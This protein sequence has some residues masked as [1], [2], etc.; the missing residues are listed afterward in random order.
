VCFTIISESFSA[1]FKYREKVI[2]G[3]KK[4]PMN[5]GYA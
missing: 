3:S 5:R 1:A 4:S 2:K